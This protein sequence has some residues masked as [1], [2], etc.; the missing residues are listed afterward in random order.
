MRNKIL[1]L[2]AIIII[3]VPQVTLAQAV[4]PCSNQN[5][6]SSI[7]KCVNQIYL[8]ALGLSGILAVLMMILGGYL[9]MSAGGNAQQSSKG[10][11]FI[12]SAIVGLGL[13]FGSYL[14]LNTINPD[15]VNFKDTSSGG[16][17]EPVITRPRN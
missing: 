14:I 17:F 11:E 3:I 8:W 16:F 7:G 1:V 12:M 2:F 5:P 9:V 10:K 6:T 13:L 15:L 4:N